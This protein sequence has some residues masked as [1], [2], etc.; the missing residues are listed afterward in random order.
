MK[1]PRTLQQQFVD[2][3]R[4]TLG[5]DPLYEAQTPRPDKERFYRDEIDERVLRVSGRVSV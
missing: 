4:E 2:A 3:L 5:K 1:D